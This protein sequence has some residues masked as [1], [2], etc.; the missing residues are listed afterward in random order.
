MTS[1]DASFADTASPAFLGGSPAF[2]EGLPLTRVQV[3]DRAGLLERLGAVLDSGMLTNGRTV[4][5]LEQRAA[6]LL[7]VP[8]VVAVSNCTAGLMLVL[9]AAGVGEG[10]PVLMPGFTFSATAHAAHWAGGTPLFAE[11]REVDITLD[12]ADAEARLKAADRPAA[13]MATHVYGTPCQTEELQ[14]IADAAGLPLVYDSA[15]GF[16]SSRKGVPVGNFGLAE[17]FSMSPTKVAVAGEGG[18]VA[19]RDAALAQTLRHGRDYGN[20]GDYNTLFPGLNARMSELHAAV[21][22]SWLAELPERVAHRGALVA[23]FARATAGLPGLRLALPEEGD[24]ST[25]KDLT[26]ILDAE[27]FGLTADELGRALKAEGIDTRRYFHP[28]VQRQQ[29]YAHLGQA[30]ALPVTDRLAASVLTV[31]LWTQMDAATVRRTAE[32]VARIQPYA[33]RLRAAGL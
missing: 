14:R 31:P 4:A 21:G 17:V 22:L 1:T 6:E 19:T 20:P 2:P 30:E 3:P 23:E 12:P 27:A 9:Q 16:G 13:L 29:A 28:P 10:R 7:D 5:E 8:H 32:A 18:L 25:F 33:E 26:L 11:A 15:H 24:V